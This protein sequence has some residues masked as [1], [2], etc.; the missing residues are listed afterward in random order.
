[1]PIHNIQYLKEMMKRPTSSHVKLDSIDSELSHVHHLQLKLKNHRLRCQLL[2]QHERVQLQTLRQRSKGSLRRDWMIFSI[3]L[4]LI[5]LLWQWTG[6]AD[7]VAD[8]IQR[9]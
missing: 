3:V 1:M 2:R 9:H 7:N 5:Y 4:L 8:L 6:L